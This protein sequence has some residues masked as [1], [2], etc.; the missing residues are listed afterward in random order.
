[1]SGSSGI[2]IRVQLLLRPWQER[3]SADSTEDQVVDETCRADPCRDGKKRAGRSD[4]N[5]LKRGPIHQID[6]VHADRRFR[7]E[8]FVG[9]SDENFR[10][11]LALCRQF[12]D[13]PYRL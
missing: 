9:C 11:A 4:L 7:L 3:S 12:L 1:M 13:A 8:D 2:V 6:V 5:R 10:I